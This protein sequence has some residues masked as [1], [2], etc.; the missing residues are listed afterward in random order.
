MTDGSVI[1]AVA[2]VALIGA[3]I[4]WW[5][6]MAQRSRRRPV[7]DRQAALIV[8]L[9]DERGCELTEAVTEALPADAA[10]EIIRNPRRRGLTVE[11][12]SAVIDWLLS[13]PR[14]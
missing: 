13:Q 4:G 14:A 8:R 1:V 9:M 12:A 10:R 2:L 7:T 6:R 3:W 11:E 5:A